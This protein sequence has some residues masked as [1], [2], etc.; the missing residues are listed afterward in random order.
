VDSASY[1][2]AFL[3]A[4]GVLTAACLLAALTPERPAAAS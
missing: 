3:L 2:A 4:G 1:P